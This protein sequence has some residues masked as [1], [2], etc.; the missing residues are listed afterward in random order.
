MGTAIKI[1]VIGAGSATF[2]LGLVKDL[3]LTESLRGS[4]VSFMDV[5]GERLQMIHRLAERYAGE[6]GADITFDRTLE[7]RAALQDADFVI[8]TASVV[9]YRSGLETHELIQKY[10]Y[11]W[12]GP[13]SLEYSFYN[14][15]FILEVARE[16]EEICPEAWLIQSGN[17]VYDGCTAIG[18]ET[19]VKVC[20]LCHG[21]YGYRDICDMLGIDHRK[22]TWQAPG[23]NHN[24]WLTRFEY[25]G[26]DA[27]PLI[28]E[29]IESKGEAYWAETAASRPMGTRK[30][31]WSGELTRAWE[32]DLSRAAVHMYRLYG[33]MPLGDTTWMK[34]I[35]WW[36]HK[37]LA[38]KRYWFG[39][40]WGGQRS[41]LSWPMYVENQERIV[42][43]IARLARDP[44]E[45]LVKALGRNKTI[46]QQVPI[47]DALVNDNEGQFQVNVPNRGALSGVP[48]DIVVE[49][50]A[51]VNKDGIHRIQV[52]PLPP[53]IMLTQILPLILSLE[54]TLL[55]IKT[56]DRSLLLW[57]L[58]DANETRSYAQAE[59]ALEAIL[60]Q[61][62][63]R[64]M[65]EYFRWPSGWEANGIGRTPVKD[66]PVLRAE[67]A[68]AAD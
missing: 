27:Y 55:A 36:Y 62:F 42:E 26:R 28:D 47:I 21:Y 16:I 59:E 19:N 38:A 23:L 14:S 22:V 56:G 66:D 5:D 3:C 17:P 29:W 48:D 35:G 65:D 6:L 68:V 61:D 2:S 45:S 24:I 30:I 10:G 40:P 64:E 7:R 50:P 37:D 44:K 32:I 11:D 67:E 13:G 25:E 49:I 58:L 41:Q 43:E 52:E 4:H 39:E 1:G 33:L 31:G 18:R 53:K 57:E 20:G 60:S 51:V 15:S 8:N 63:H 54:R 12:D 46:E 9:T 34:R